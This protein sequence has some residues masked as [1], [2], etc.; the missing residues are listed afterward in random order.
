MSV[1]KKT[2][3]H[4]LKLQQEGSKL[5]VNNYILE[6]GRVERGWICLK[7]LWDGRQFTFWILLL[8]LLV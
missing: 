3:H 4:E 7:M 1:V 5:F 8:I 2:R 6:I